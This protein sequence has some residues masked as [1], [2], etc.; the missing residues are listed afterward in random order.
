MRPVTM[1]SAAL[2]SGI[3]ASARQ[4]E[5][6]PGGCVNYGAA[7][8][9]RTDFAHRIAGE[10]SVDPLP[11]SQSVLGMLLLFCSGPQCLNV[12]ALLEKSQKTF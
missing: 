6:K 9:D 2:L 7:G 4:A 11:D 1:L 10:N 12:P 8:G 5:A 3:I